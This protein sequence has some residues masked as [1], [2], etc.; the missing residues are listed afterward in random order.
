MALDLYQNF[1][2]AQYLENTVLQIILTII[3]EFFSSFWEHDP[4]NWDF[5]ALLYTKLG[6]LTLYNKMI[7]KQ[8]Q[9]FGSLI[10]TF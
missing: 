10:S 8:N 3:T 7:K 4:Y 1:V 6:K 2:S 9:I 5:F